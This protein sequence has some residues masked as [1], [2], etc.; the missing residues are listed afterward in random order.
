MLVSTNFENIKRRPRR[1][2]QALALANG[3]VMDAVV[4]S[5]NFAVRGHQFTPGIFDRLPLLLKIGIEKLLVVAARDETNLLRIGLFEEPQ[6]RSPGLFTH[7]GLMHVTQRKQGSAQLLLCQTK[8]KIG[9]VLRQIGRTSENPSSGAVVVFVA[10]IVSGGQQ[11]GANLPG[12]HE[13]LIELQMIVAEAARN[14]CSSRQVVLNEGSN[15]VMLKSR[16]LVHYV[17]GDSQRLR[18]VPGIIHIVDRAATSLDSLWHAL[19][20]G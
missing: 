4:R 15:Y 8:Q 2:S 9:L 13:Q 11:V 19:A 5:D 1:H 7:R 20:S 6:P 3:K 16:L 18:D 12:S 10:G 14:R 17:V